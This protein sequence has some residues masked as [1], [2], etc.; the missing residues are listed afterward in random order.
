[1]LSTPPKPQNQD[2][3][4]IGQSQKVR[5]QSSPQQALQH[6]LQ[7]P[8]IVARWAGL[9]PK[10]LRSPGFVTRS[11]KTALRALL[12]VEVKGRAAW[13]PFLLELL[14]GHGGSQTGVRCQ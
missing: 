1:M 7:N 5:M 14:G 9:A 6:G 10:W 12:F 13:A 11:N 2:R 3:E 4:K 8:Q